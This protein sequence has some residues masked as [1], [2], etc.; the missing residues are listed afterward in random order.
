MNTATASA[1]TTQGPPGGGSTPAKS[2][3]AFG[4]AIWKTKTAKINAELFTLTYGSVVSQLCSDYGR[5]FTKVNDQLY[6]MGRSIGVRLIEDFVAR[7]ALPRC[8]NMVHT[9]EVISKV[10]FKVFLNITPQVANWNAARDT[11]SLLIDENPLSDF[12]ELPMDAM[13]ELWY[14]NIL[15]GVLKGALEMVQLDCQ[16]WFVS[17]VLRGDP[18][19]EMKI[20]LNRI[21]KEEIPA[22]ED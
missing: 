8:E 14:S 6:S 11:F 10:A 22:G 3:K 19:T 9:S 17:D 12:V 21:L 5:D 16:V 2:L 4:E 20:K 13:K 1:G 15:C 7:A 18:H